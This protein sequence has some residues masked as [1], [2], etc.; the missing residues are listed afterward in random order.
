MLI[1][2]YEVLCRTQSMVL[3]KKSKHRNLRKSF[4]GNILF[5]AAQLLGIWKTRDEIS[6]SGNTLR[7][8]D[9]SQS[10]EKFGIKVNSITATVRLT[11]A[12]MDMNLIF[13]LNE[14][15]RIRKGRRGDK[16]CIVDVRR[17]WLS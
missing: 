10:S 13:R 6:L 16:G 14:R 2:K 8:A 1:T 3:G 17:I 12:E 5:S 9:N 11:S 4:A 7:L 15:R